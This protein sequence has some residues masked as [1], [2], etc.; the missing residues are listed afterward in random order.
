[1]CQKRQT[2]QSKKPIAYKF[3]PVCAHLVLLTTAPSTT[4]QPVEY[5]NKF[6]DQ[7]NSSKQT[8][9]HEEVALSN[10]NK[11]SKLERDLSKMDHNQDL[12]LSMLSLK[13]DDN[14]IYANNLFHVS[15][16]EQNYTL[17]DEFVQCWTG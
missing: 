2:P 3:N 14:L 1:M 15:L 5:I 4:H 7:Q 6:P 16:L 10:L 9:Q 17:P 11:I 12:L 8:F 13:N